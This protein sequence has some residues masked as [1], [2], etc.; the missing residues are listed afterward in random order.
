[1]NLL[2]VVD[3]DGYFTYVQGV[4]MG[5]LVDATVY[6]YCNI[7]ALPAGLLMLADWVFLLEETCLFLPGVERCKIFKEEK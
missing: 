2:V 4:F 1:M 7:P 5:H 6:R 3:M